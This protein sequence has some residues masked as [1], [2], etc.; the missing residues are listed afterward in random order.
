M[1]GN[2]DA[3]IFKLVKNKPDNL[4]FKDRFFVDTISDKKICLFHGDPQELVNAIFDSKRYDVVLRGHNHE[5]E[6]KT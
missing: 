3:D 2:N 1:T 6:V 4:E 5:A